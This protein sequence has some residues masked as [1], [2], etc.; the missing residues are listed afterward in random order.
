MTKFF[1]RIWFKLT[2][3]KINGSFPLEIKKMILLVAPHTSWKDILVGLATRSRLKIY[4]AKFLGKKEL[5]DGPFGWYFRW[6]GG[7]PVDRHSKHG[8]VE[9]VVEMYNNNEE[10]IIALSPEGTR[11]K[12]DK[13]RTGFY[14]IAVGAGVPILPIAMDYKTKQIRFMPL[15]YPTGDY[16]ADLPKILENYRGVLGKH[17]EKMS[18]P[19]QD[20][21][22]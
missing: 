19:L 12:V 7:V 11:K 1:W 21:H 15:F 20:V 3:W 4:K 16:D 9:Q 8:M 22:G 18:Q 17:F 2:G 13:L 6:L 10:F 5:F 14:H